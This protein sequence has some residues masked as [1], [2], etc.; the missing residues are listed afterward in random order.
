MSTYLYF[1]I[2]FHIHKVNITINYIHIIFD[3]CHIQNSFLIQQRT[4][5]GKGYTSRSDGGKS[6]NKIYTIFFLLMV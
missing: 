2:T 3:S 4:L 5:I 1:N 6:Y